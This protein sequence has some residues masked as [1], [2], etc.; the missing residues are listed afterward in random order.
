MKGGSPNPLRRTFGL[1]QHRNHTNAPTGKHT[2]DN[3]ER[4]GSGAGLHRNT[5]GEDDDSKGDGPSPTEEIG[6]GGCE[7]G[8]EEGAR[9]QDGNDEGLLR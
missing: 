5:S 1:N 2:T 7:E 4:K 3:E 6:G 8:T 9:G